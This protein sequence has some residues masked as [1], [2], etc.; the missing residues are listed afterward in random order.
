MGSSADDEEAVDEDTNQPTHSAHEGKGP[1]SVDQSTRPVQKDTQSSIDISM[2]ETSVLSHKEIDKDVV[3]SQEQSDISEVYEPPEPDTANHSDSAV[4]SRL[5]FG[6]R[7]PKPPSTNLQHA[8]LDQKV[9]TLTLTD[10]GSP[11]AIPTANLK[12][13]FCYFVSFDEVLIWFI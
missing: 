7:S 10:Q 9:E 6:E 5:S 4:A 13:F 2:G 11:V 3:S 1:A 8:P 12:V